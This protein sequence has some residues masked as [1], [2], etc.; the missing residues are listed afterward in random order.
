MKEARGRSL[1]LSAP[2]KWMGDLAALSRRI[3][4]AALEHRL[5]LQPLIEVRDL[6]PKPH[7]S[8]V[9]LFLKAFA[10]VAQ[11]RPQLRRGYFNFPWP[12]LY[13][14]PVSVAA[15]TAELE[16][17]G[18]PAVFFDLL[19]QPEKKSVMEIHR[20][21][22]GLKCDPITANPCFRLLLLTERVP[23]PLRRLAWRWLYSF[24]GPRRATYMG[25]FAIN[26]GLRHPI[27]PVT[28]TGAIGTTLYFGLFDAAGCTD[29]CLT[30]D[31]RVLDGGEVVR[32]LD[33]LESVLNTD[34]RLELQALAQ[35]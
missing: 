25:T 13:E 28:T 7:P 29:V 5:C 26:A 32:T 15:I 21:L 17:R 20:H 27:R 11:H 24:S 16:W 2:R 12:R 19:P 31:H 22:R 9:A 30:F 10:L 6:L 18:E 23:L 4:I 14:H 8:W 1:P 3:P 35:R 33:A 34:I